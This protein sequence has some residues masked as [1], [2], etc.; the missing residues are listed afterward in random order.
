MKAAILI[1][2]GDLAPKSNPIAPEAATS[3]AVTRLPGYAASALAP[4]RG[5]G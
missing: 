1:S 4:P 3:P 2:D 5:L